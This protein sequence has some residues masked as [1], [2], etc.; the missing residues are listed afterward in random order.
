MIILCIVLS[1]MALFYG[2]FHADFFSWG[3][4]I[5]SLAHPYYRLGI[6]FEP[7][8][9]VDN[10]GDQYQIHKFTLGLVLVNIYFNFY[11]YQGT[12]PAITNDTATNTPLATV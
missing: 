11:T 8:F 6:T 2:F 1:L 9:Y 3:V 5:I 7:Q 12:Q 10:K 4:D